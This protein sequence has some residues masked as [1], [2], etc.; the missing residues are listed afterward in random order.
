[1]LSDFNSYNAFGIPQE[2]IEN[3]RFRWTVVLTIYPAIQKDLKWE[4]YHIILT[5]AEPLLR[6]ICL[7]FFFYRT[8]GATQPHIATDYEDSHPITPVFFFNSHDSVF[9]PP[10]VH[11]HSKSSFVSQRTIVYLMYIL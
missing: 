7:S 2:V 3:Q 5:L 8:N 6:S 11:K 1:M 10:L 4:N 9:A